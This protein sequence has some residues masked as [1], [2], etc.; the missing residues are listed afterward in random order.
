MLSF[1]SFTSPTSCGMTILPWSYNGPNDPMLLQVTNIGVTQN[2]PPSTRSF[3]SILT[4]QNLPKSISSRSVPSIPVAPMNLT[5]TL[6]NDYDPQSLSYVWNPVN[7]SEGWYMLLATIPTEAF[8]QNSLPFFVFTGIDTSCLSLVDISST[9]GTTHT[10]SPSSSSSSASF[11]S[12]VTSISASN[13]SS[14]STS[15]APIIIGVTVG[16]G[17]LAIASLII[18]ALLRKRR[19]RSSNGISKNNSLRWNGWNSPD[20][21]EGAFGANATNK[22]SRSHLSSQPSSIATS[23]GPDSGD[24]ILGAE[25]GLNLKALSLSDEHGLALSTLPVLHHQ[26]SRARTDHTYSASSSSS[27]LDEFGLPVNK[28]PSGQYSIQPSISSAV[29]PPS[30]AISSRDS[31]QDVTVSDISRSHSLSTTGTQN[32][33]DQT[34]T[35]PSSASALSSF[36]FPPPSKEAKQMNRQSLG[37]KR[38]PVPVYDASEEEEQPTSINPFSANAE[39]LALPELSHKGSFGPCGIEGKQLHYLI[40][41][42]PMSVDR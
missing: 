34:S 5:M 33:I 20:S 42:M 3:S 29:Y 7:V 8:I 25:K 9:T 24:G 38:K 21:R 23:I 32:P 27:N 10:P 41:D 17:V 36:Q 22:R 12:S 13:L 28:P 26:L 11:N 18:W 16:M 19:S 40:P 39:S 6:A 14:T 1:Q 4:T 31:A 37:R 30:F 35:Y 2:P 15:K